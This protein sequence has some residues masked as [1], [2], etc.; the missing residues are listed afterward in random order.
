MFIG[1]TYAAFCFDEAVLH[2]G[3]AVEEHVTEAGR[4]A[5]NDKSRQA[6][7]DNALRKMLGQQPKFRDGME[8]VRRPQPDDPDERP[9]APFRME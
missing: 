4:K 8:L 2:F 5:K 7:Q 9:D 6:K 3:N 1:D